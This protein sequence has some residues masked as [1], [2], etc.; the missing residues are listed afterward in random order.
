LKL[1]IVG[2]S[3]FLEELDKSPLSLEEAHSFFKEKLM[4]DWETDMQTR[5]R[6]SW[7]ENVG[8]I[9]REG[10]GYVLG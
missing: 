6:I 7:L 8:A 4:V 3:E 9:R 10:E 2:I 1:K 5:F